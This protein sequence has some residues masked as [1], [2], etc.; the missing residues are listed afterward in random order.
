[1]HNIIN[2]GTMDSR[3]VEEVFEDLIKKDDAECQE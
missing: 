2:N 1:M 3:T